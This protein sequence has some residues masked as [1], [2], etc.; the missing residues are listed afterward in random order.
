MSK[1][2]TWR[3][4]QRALYKTQR[5]MGDVDAATRGPDKY[6]KRVVRRRVTRS[7]FRMFR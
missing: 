6:V 3:E 5:A 4:L 2:S 7:I 1:R